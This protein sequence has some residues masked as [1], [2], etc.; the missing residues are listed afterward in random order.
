MVPREGKQKEATVLILKSYLKHINIR[1]QQEGM[2][3]RLQGK[4]KCEVEVGSGRKGG[5]YSFRISTLTAWDSSYAP[6]FCHQLIMA[7]DPFLTLI[8]TSVSVEE[9]D[10]NIV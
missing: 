4:W 1:I 5:S 3:E 6:T 10:Y 2:D 7:W 8:P 9:T